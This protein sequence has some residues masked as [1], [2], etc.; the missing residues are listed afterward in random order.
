MTR[1]W[2][3][4]PLAA[5]AATVAVA[6]VP[7]A[8]S[9]QNGEETD[10]ISGDIV[11]EDGLELTGKVGE[12][13]PFDVMA[14]VLGLK[15]HGSEEILQVYCIDIHNDIDFDAPYAEGSGPSREWRTWR[16]SAGSWR[17]GTRT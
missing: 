4:A 10:P 2:R 14:N 11:V 17:T 16:T 7:A 12:E 3:L 13:D 1:P 15:P 9:A 8:A 5:A 6:L